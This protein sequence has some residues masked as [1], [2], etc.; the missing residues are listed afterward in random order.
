MLDIILSLNVQGIISH[1]CGLLEI[2]SL[3]FSY[4][5]LNTLPWVFPRDCMSLVDTEQVKESTSAKSW[6]QSSGVFG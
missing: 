6:Q 1:L 5:Q 4:H 2:S 3:V